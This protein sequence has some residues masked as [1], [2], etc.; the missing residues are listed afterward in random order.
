VPGAAG[1]NN[2]KIDPNLM[3]LED[4]VQGKT[5]VYMD[6]E[7]HPSYVAASASSGARRRRVLM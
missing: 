7:R 3:V 5:Q 6:F 2:V 4:D 1:S